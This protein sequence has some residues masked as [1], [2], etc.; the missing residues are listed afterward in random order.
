MVEREGEGEEQKHGGGLI[1]GPGYR[2]ATGNRRQGIGRAGR[3]R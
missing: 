1:E 2:D 3:R